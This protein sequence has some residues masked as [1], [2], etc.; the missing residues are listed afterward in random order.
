MAGLTLTG[1]QYFIPSIVQT[2]GYQAIQAQLYS[3]IPWAVTAVFSLALAFASDKVQ[4]R[5][6]FIL[7]GLCLAVSGNL[8]LFTVHNNRQVEFAGLVL[9]TMGNECL[10]PIVVCWFSMNLRGHRKKSIGTAWQIGFGNL[11]GIVATFAF[12]SADAPRYHLGYSLGLA[13]L[14]L[15]GAA[16][17]AYFLGC[18][19]DRKLQEEYRVLL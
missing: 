11:S 7:L 4:L 13:S 19:R 10:I 12:P 2:Y 17:L 15:T 8:V 6:P 3:V 14:C 18:L 1:F 16:S 9:Y 5:S